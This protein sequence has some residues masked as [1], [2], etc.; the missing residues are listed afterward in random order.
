MNPGLA[1]SDGLLPFW[2][3]IFQ[4]QR[5]TINGVVETDAAYMLRAI[6]ELFGQSSSLVVLR[7]EFTK[8]GITNFTLE[9]SRDDTFK[10][11]T[12][13]EPMSVNLHLE[14]KDFDRIPFLRELFFNISVAGMR[15]FIFCPAQDQ[16]CYGLNYG[17]GIDAEDYETPPPFTPT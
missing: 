17:Y 12:L 7:R 2:E 5:K 8:Y 3:A 14:E 4:S 9:N 6:S 15:L 1:T 10:W 16:D 11:N 13:M